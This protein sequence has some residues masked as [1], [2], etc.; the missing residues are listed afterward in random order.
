VSEAESK[1]ALNTLKEHGFQDTLKK[2]AELLGMV[3][4]HGRGLLKGR[5]WPV[6]PKL[7]FDK[8]AAPILENM[9]SSGSF[10]FASSIPFTRTNLRYHFPF[11]S[12]HKLFPI[13]SQKI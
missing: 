2:M 7:V 12:I 4:T 11:N 8:M 3:H 13:S 1:A 6:G 9:D 5:W 10:L